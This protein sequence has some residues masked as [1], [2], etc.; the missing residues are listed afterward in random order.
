MN[1]HRFYLT[2]PGYIV[3]VA[4][5]L[6]AVLA[7]G[8]AKVNAQRVGIVYSESSAAKYYDKFTYN[9]LFTAVQ[10]QARMAGIPY[11]LLNEDDLADIN[12]LVGHQALIIPFMPNVK[13]AKL[14]AIEAAL[15]QAVS[16]Y[17]IGLITGGDLMTVSETGAA[18]TNSASRLNRWF[19]VTLST[20]AGN[21]VATSLL[22]TSVTHPAMRDYTANEVIVSW[23][24][25][26]FGSYVPVTGQ[27]AT[28][29]ATLKGGTTNYNGVIATQTGGRNV[30]FANE[31][32][33][34]STNLLW[35]CIQWV[36]YG[37][38][39]PVALTMGR[40]KSLFTSRTDM[41]QSMFIDEVSV[42]EVPL[43]NLLSTWKTNYNFIGSFYLN[44]GNNVAAGET[45]NWAVSG[46]LYQNYL[47][48]GNEI[49]THSW[50]HPNST[51][52]L[53]TGQL[54]F[55]FNQ[56]KNTI[57]AQLGI[58]V[59]GTAI[60]GV[61]ESIAVENQ[62]DT[63]FSYI[64]GRYGALDNGFPGGIGR[65]TPGAKSIYWSLTMDPDF[66]LIEDQKKTPA[67]AQTIWANEMATTA[68]HAAMPIHH[69][70]W[71]DYAPTVS[72]NLY[73]ASL[74]PNT[75]A[76]AKSAG[77]EFA[78]VAD[79]TQRIRNFEG[80][81]ITVVGT[82]P[83]IANVTAQGVGQFSLRPPSNQ[84]IS[85]VTNWYA[86][87]TTQV[88]L[89]DNGGTFTIQLGSSPAAFSHITELPM[90]ARLLSVTG[91][92]NGLAF[93][94][95]GEGTVKVSMSPT[96]AA[97]LSV[98]GATSFSQNGAQLSLVFTGGGMHNC[99]L[100]YGP[101]VNQPPVAANK[102]A[103][104]QNPN[105]VAITLSATDA[106]NDALTFAIVAAPANG[107]L[108]G[109]APNLT[110]TPN[111]GF[112]GNDSFTYKANDG[113]ADSNIA[114]VSITVTPAN[115][116]PVANNK[117][118]TTIQPTAVAVVL[119]ATDANNDPL[120]YAVVTGPA[121]GTLTGTA[122]NLTYTPNATFAGND[123]FTFTAN[124]GKATSNIATVS[125]T[126]TPA[127]ANQPPVAANKSVTT[128]QALAVA[129]FLTATDA[130]NDPLTY[131]VVTGPTSGVLTGT[132]PNL[133]YTPNAT[134]SGNDSFTFRANDGKANGNTATVSITV[135]PALQM[136]FTS[137]AAE[138]GWVLE[139]TE[140]SNV[141]GF[142]NSSSAS[143]QAI[144]LGDDDFNRQYKS[145][146]SFNTSA[147]PDT[148]TILS[149]RLELT[150]GSTTGTDAFTTHG[151]AKVDIKSGGFN[152][153]VALQL[154][155]FQAAADVSAVATFGS[156][157]DIGSVF[158][159]TLGS[160][161]FSKVSLTASTQLRLSLT[162]DD[163]N[164]TEAT[165]VGF[166]SGGSAANLAPRLIVTYR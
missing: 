60:P 99:T 115:Q 30:H 41:D 144:R 157:G 126:V 55:E 162:L 154:A 123:S 164:D 63:Y 24:K 124:D 102:A 46:P 36:V 131:A 92:G 111:V 83:I 69:W 45:T 8:L 160:T 84:P 9:Q 21:G 116:P 161:A 159:I 136:I 141:G 33:L 13:A 16:T 27:T 66:T 135:T 120:T 50:T 77:A 128:E 146:L 32:V 22:A 90:R 29:L 23:P 85:A 72:T 47:A 147:L 100:G 57:G 59:V 2:A 121:S 62:L 10:N 142:M 74:I 1:Q 79:V 109:T 140:T 15:D 80:S 106:N 4:M 134:F 14:A 163:N 150:R 88:F 61:A 114:T 95:N 122:P 149:V 155:D 153:N 166:H 35:S 91:D 49:G 104:T 56:S 107:Q 93:S 3:R 54:E 39:T 137:M 43:L 125:I 82:N 96:L 19:G 81:V 71:H 112:S 89:P 17:H 139:S 94:F 101:P 152:N 129:I 48:L 132:A 103:S 130:N 73:S 76:T 97:G 86:Y 75:I 5:P 42:T 52:T 145:I 53:T 65:L 127:P 6:L 68:K 87:D 12:K 143:G 7:F 67:Q 58:S 148:A 158:G 110:Y 64:S 70:L 34:G 11:D 26:W 113:Q 25:F 117:S 51:S 108:S 138:D 165:Y 118:V 119:T 98:T 40:M 44:I 28:V 133:T 37:D 156:L 78:T 105:S 151:L 18:L 20:A 38:Q 31:E